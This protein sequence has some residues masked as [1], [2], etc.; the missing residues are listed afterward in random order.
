MSLT[1]SGL[2]VMILGTVFVENL[3]FSSACSNELTAKVVEYAPMAF[4][5]IMA[6]IG[7][8]RVGGIKWYGTRN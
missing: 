4:G 3:G 8:Y 1:Y 5:A 2:A 7:R 6:A